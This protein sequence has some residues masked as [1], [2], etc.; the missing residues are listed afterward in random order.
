MV[1]EHN[2]QPAP[3]ANGTPVIAAP[4]EPVPTAAPADQPSWLG[5]AAPMAGIRVGD[6]RFLHD[7]DW[8]GQLAAAQRG[9]MSWGIPAFFV[10]FGS[11]YVVSLIIT[12]VFS[13]LVI[14]LDN[15]QSGGHGPLVLLALTPNVLLGL[16]PA[17]FS[18]W[19]GQG[20]RRDYG[21]VPTRRDLWI[22]V[23]CG[24]VALGVGLLVNLLLQGLVFKDQGVSNNAVQQLSGLSGGRSAWLL[25]AALFVVLG[26]PLTEELLVRGALWGAL[27]HYKIHRYAIL[28]LT[29]LIFAFMHQEPTLTL[30]LFCQGIAIGTARMITGRIGASMIAHATNNLVPALILLFA[31]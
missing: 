22:G 21:I 19:K 12:G 5:Y 8:E 15:A 3:D 2:G 31:T 13:S 24:L 30:A 6:E 26:A 7:R 10:G 16:G 1:D 17:V 20:L 25:V 23:L 28:A 29:S 4:P 18:W 27:E 9:P 14:K 11:F